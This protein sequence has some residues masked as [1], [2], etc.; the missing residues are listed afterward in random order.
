M[1]LESEF[2]F[3]AKGELIQA[4]P[5]CSRSKNTNART[6]DYVSWEEA[7]GQILETFKSLDAV[8]KL[9]WSIGWYLNCFQYPYAVEE[10]KTAT[11]DTRTALKTRLDTINDELK[12]LQGLIPCF[13]KLHP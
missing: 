9:C 4:S 7:E 3:D 13:P 11:E 8:V 6:T 5:L 10:A 12:T 2:Q 1:H